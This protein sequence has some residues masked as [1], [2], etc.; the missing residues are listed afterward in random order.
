MQISFEDFRPC[1]LHKTFFSPKSVYHNRVHDG[2]DWRDTKKSHELLQ[3]QMFSLEFPVWVCSREE[4]SLVHAEIRER[5]LRDSRQRWGV[6][7]GFDARVQHL[8]PKRSV[9]SAHCWLRTHEITS[10]PLDGLL[11]INL[12]KWSWSGSRWWNLS[13]TDLRNG[14]GLMEM[15]G[16]RIWSM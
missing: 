6:P 9:N 12:I 4:V 15:K 2:A 1:M 8:L 11:L 10:N 7:Y 3:F 16:K 14:L 5:V 13:N